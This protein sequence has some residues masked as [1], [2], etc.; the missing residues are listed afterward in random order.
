MRNK[1]AIICGSSAA[2]WDDYRAA[3]SLCGIGGYLWD[4]ENKPG[5]EEY[6]VLHCSLNFAGIFTRELDH[7]LITRLDN[8]V[9]LAQARTRVD[10]D[11]GLG[12]VR[13]HTPGH[14][15]FPPLLS[16]H[17]FWSVPTKGTIAMF[18]VKVLSSMGCRRMILA[19]VPLDDEAGYFYRAPWEKFGMSKESKV[20]W[21]EMAETLKPYVRSMSGWTRELLG[22]PSEEWLRGGLP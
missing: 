14:P 21:Q 8:V 3:A 11:R 12:G 6:R 22:S 4:T 16:N 18:A 15:N 1:V 17:E 10:G 20:Y 7:W 9:P 19:G 5:P 2:L 13:V